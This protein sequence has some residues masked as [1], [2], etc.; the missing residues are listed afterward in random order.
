MKSLNNSEQVPDTVN[1]DENYSKITLGTEPTISESEQRVLGVNW[2]FVEDQLVFD[3]SGIVELAKKYKP[4]KRNIVRLSGKFYDPLG[5][6]SP[7][8]VQFKNMFQ[9]LCESKVGWDDEIC[10]SDKSQ[11][12]LPF[13]D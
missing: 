1:E 3:L 6:M 11:M 7:I 8:T 4:T 13:L 12:V 5:Y 10:T 2:N 9:E